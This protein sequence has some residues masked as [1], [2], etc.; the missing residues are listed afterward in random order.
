LDLSLRERIQGRPRRK[1]TTILGFR[2]GFGLT[3]DTLYRDSFFSLSDSGQAL[4]NYRH[5]PHSIFF[6]ICIVGHFLV[7][8]YLISHFKPK[9]IKM[10][11]IKI[12]AHEGYFDFFFFS[13]SCLL[14][15]SISHAISY[16]IFFIYLFIKDKSLLK[17]RKSKYIVCVKP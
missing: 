4:D 1:A 10:T 14:I 9:Y 5:L 13:F 7:L 8:L 12:Q 6:C 15:H 2:K 17:G 16:S 3:V 11:L